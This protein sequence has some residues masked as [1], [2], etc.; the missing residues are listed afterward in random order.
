MRSVSGNLVLGAIG[1][2]DGDGKL[3]VVVN[4]VSVGIIRDEYARYE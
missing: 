1:D 2:V 3:D 4:L